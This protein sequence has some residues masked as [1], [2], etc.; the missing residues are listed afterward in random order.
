MNLSHR[1]V[2]NELKSDIDEEFGEE[3]VWISQAGQSARLQGTFSIQD[4]EVSVGGKS[5]KS[6]RLYL[7]SMTATFS[8]S[9]VNLLCKE[10]DFLEIGGVRYVILPFNFDEFSVVLPLKIAQEKDPNWR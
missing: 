9:P 8:V 3:A 2:L 4:E 7:D 5:S 10:G 6:S 1:A